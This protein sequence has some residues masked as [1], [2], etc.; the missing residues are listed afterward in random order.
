MALK[1]FKRKIWMSIRKIF[2]SNDEEFSPHGI[3]VRIPSNA[4]LGIRYSL[5]LGR[6][7]EAPE[8]EMVDKYL[9]FGKN[10]IELGGCYGIISALI[11]KKIGPHAKH[12]IVEADP[13]LA[14][15]CAAN[16]NLGNINNKAD[17]VV[18]AVD[19]SGAEQ[20]T[21]AHGDNAHG[22]HVATTGEVGFTVPTTT[23]AEQVLK[24]P[25]REYIPVCDI[26]GSELELSKREKKA[27]S[28]IYLLI[29]EMHPD[30]YPRKSLDYQQI[31]KNI[32]NAGLV[33]IE[34]S[35]E[36]ICFAS[37]AA[38]KELKID[39]QKLI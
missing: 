2:I 39:H 14:K 16:A 38:I 17:V 1:T 20:I 12:I 3:K 25:E 35:N 18:A 28:Q 32:E 9:S 37:K 13:S 5:A 36:V 10:V 27:L 31:Q 22:G 15:I 6:P 8:A 29:L 33:E 23:L 11:R 21:F 30:V 24:L 4:D 34:K 19:Y 7:Y 26:E